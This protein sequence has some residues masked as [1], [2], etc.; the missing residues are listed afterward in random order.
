M[1]SLN[2]IGGQQD[3]ISKEITI[4]INPLALHDD[5]RADEQPYLGMAEVHEPVRPP[6][7]LKNLSGIKKKLHAHVGYFLSIQHQS[8][9]Q[10]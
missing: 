7:R 6:R 4:E 2:G 8:N 3:D 5:Q 9:I 10:L 1:T